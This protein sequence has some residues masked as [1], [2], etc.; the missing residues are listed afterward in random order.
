MHDGVE[1]RER[2][3]I[4]ESRKGEGDGKRT[5]VRRGAVRRGAVGKKNEELKE[6]KKEEEEEVVVG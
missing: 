6:K 1:R 2:E 5:M 4:L 3:R